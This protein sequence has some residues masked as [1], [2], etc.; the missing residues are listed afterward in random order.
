MS[1]AKYVRRTCINQS[2][3]TVKS[4]YNTKL[5]PLKSNKTNQLDE[6]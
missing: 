6:T 4:S 1:K 2:M 3:F 5:C